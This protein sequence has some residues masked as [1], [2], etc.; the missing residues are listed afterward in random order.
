MEEA[1]TTTP[2]LSSEVATELYQWTFMFQ[3]SLTGQY[4]NN[5]I[6]EFFIMVMENTVQLNLDI[7]N[8]HF[9]AKSMWTALEL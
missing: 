5:K 2:T 8:V 6:Y 3:V 4:G 7:S 9:M 1:T